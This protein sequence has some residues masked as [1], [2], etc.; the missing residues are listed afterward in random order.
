M[1]RTDQ[2]VPQRKSTRLVARLGTGDNWFPYGISEVVSHTDESFIAVNVARSTRG[3]ADVLMRE[4][5]C[6]DPEACH[7]ALRIWLQQVGAD[8]DANVAE[9]RA[10]S[11]RVADA[12]LG[13]V[14]AG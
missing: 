7:A 10:W 1:S 6:R 3:R 5:D 13:G 8:D 14:A 4:F 2:N 9:V 11:E 12:I